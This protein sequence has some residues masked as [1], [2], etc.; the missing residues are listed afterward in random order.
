MITC[1]SRMTSR[2]RRMAERLERKLDD[3][4]VIWYDVP[5]GPKRSRLDFV[6]CNQMKMKA[7]A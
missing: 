3:D 1:V 4:Y 7:N 5:G 6:A 2:E